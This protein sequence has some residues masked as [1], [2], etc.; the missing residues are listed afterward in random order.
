MWKYP[1]SPEVTGFTITIL[2]FKT[3]VKEQVTDWQANFDCLRIPLRILSD[4]TGSEFKLTE[5]FAVDWN[6][7]G[8]LGNFEFYPP[9]SRT[10]YKVDLTE[11][12]SYKRKQDV[13]SV[14]ND[15]LMKQPN[16]SKWNIFTNTRDRHNRVDVL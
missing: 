7:N 4:P 1:P 10:G 12:N 6:F 14:V 8:T 9:G 2:I 11:H 16:I 13:F 5:V 3:S 15:F